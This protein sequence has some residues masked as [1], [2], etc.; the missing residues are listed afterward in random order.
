MNANNKLKQEFIED[1]T[2]AIKHLF[3]NIKINL[4]ADCSLDV[5]LN[6]DF[7]PCFYFEFFPYLID[8]D[9]ED[10]VGLSLIGNQITF[11]ERFMQLISSLN[12]AKLTELIDEVK[13]EIS[14]G[15]LQL[16]N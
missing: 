15:R 13:G 9:F 6:E 1:S 12:L 11:D 16:A 4:L 7:Q 8:E 14:F 5:S 10:T 2:Y 3:E